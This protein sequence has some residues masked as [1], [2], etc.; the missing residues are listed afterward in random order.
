MNIHNVYLRK[1]MLLLLKVRKEIQMNQQFE[2]R[3][4]LTSI[5][6]RNEQANVDRNPTVFCCEILA[7]SFWQADLRLTYPSSSFLYKLSSSL[8]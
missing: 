3:L 6:Y 5:H 4:I 1:R 2:N 8:F 7:G